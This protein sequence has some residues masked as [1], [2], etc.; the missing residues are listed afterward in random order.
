M[1]RS[2][3]Y[4]VRHWAGFANSRNPWH[5]SFH[6]PTAQ[7]KKLVLEVL[8]VL[9]TSH[10]SIAPVD[11]FAWDHPTLPNY[12]SCL[13]WSTLGEWWCID[14][15]GIHSGFSRSKCESLNV[16]KRRRKNTRNVQS[17]I[18]LQN[19]MS[20]WA[21]GKPQVTSFI[22]KFFPKTKIDT[23]LWLDTLTIHYSAWHPLPSYN[24]HLTQNGLPCTWR[25]PCKIAWD[26]QLEASYFAHE[27]WPKPV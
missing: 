4:E 24:A 10:L 21:R 8:V 12:Q 17:Q 7:R 25:N 14:G 19:K 26:K 3:P 27:C 22:E 2:Y 15:Y 5:L 6:I 1:I 18:F 20:N 16:Q 23:L 11:S 13:S 9:T